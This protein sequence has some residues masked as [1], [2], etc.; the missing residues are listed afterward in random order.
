[1]VD[2]LLLLLPKMEV[3]NPLIAPAL[4]KPIC[5]KH[6]YTVKTIDY[7]VLLWRELQQ[8][9]LGEIWIDND[10]TFVDDKLFEN[11]W[12]NHIDK[13]SEKW[14]DDISR[15]SPKFIGITLL[16]HWTHRVA[17][18]I[19]EKINNRFPS[20]KIILGGPGIGPDFSRNL[21][22]KRKIYA[23]V[24]GDGEKAIIDVLKGNLDAPGINGNPPE[25]VRDLDVFPFP[26]YS[27]FDL[28]LYSSKFRDPLSK[29]YGAK[30]LYITGSRGCI[31][32]CTFCN[33]GAI[34]PEFASKSGRRIADEIE[35]LKNE[36]NV[37]EFFFTDSLL[38]ADVKKLIQMS[39]EIIKRKLNVTWGG[40]FIVRTPKTMPPEVYKLLSQAGCTTMLL[41]VESGSQKILN[42]MKKGMRVEDITY[43]FEQCSK[44]N[45][46]AVVML[47][48]GYP[49]ETEEDF[50]E[51][52][53]F[54]RKQQP[55]TLDGTI[56]KLSLGPTTK[57]YPDTPLA[58]NMSRMGIKIDQNGDWVYGDNDMK[59]RIERW[60]RL[61]DEA[62]KLGYNLVMETPK[63]LLRRYKKITGKDLL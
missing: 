20:I 11:I 7:N 34:W 22:I 60:F 17:S 38:N 56:S 54:L 27:G 47:I 46:K 3:H 19:I 55:Y 28:G 24:E 48:V 40:Q 41:G 59:T 9:G 23:F 39:G 12:N 8:R 13:I 1:M 32:R 57:I 10:Q 43:T 61:R 29:Q 53:N 14:M 51:N 30:F 58:F 35:Y 45:I 52:I 42:E 50:Q 26:D 44:N 2:L 4:L 33:V 63:F 16:S 15:L 49:T 62:L 18:K 31:R 6:G 36:C 25:Q 37:R 21:L 5:E